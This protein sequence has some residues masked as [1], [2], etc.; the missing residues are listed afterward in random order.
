MRQDI[1]YWKNNSIHLLEGK[2]VDLDSID[3]CL[4]VDLDYSNTSD[5]YGYWNAELQCW[6]HKS[7]DSFPNGFK[8][9]LLIMGVR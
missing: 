8:T 6:M 4:S 9:A 3:G 7:F 2:H 1:Y 5:R